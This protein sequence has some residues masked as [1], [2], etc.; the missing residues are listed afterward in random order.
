M[1]TI[2]LAA[3][4]VVGLVTQVTATE[5]CKSPLM[6]INTLGNS[7]LKQY[8]EVLVGTRPSRFPTTLGLYVSPTGTWTIVRR[9]GK[10]ACIVEAG[11]DW[12]APTMMVG[13]SA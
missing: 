3:A 13:T 11:T 10:R 5:D 2:A 4:V 1:H 12:E 6:T 7:L 8:G 9:N